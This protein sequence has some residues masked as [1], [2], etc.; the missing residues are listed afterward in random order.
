MAKL[1]EKNITLF[2]LKNTFTQASNNTELV[3]FTIGFLYNIALNKAKLPI[4]CKRN[5]QN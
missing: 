4:S 3:F 2:N 5:Y 1:Y